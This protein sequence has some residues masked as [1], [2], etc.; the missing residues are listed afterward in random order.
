[1]RV[2]PSFTVLIVDDD[3]AVRDVLVQVIREKGLRVFATS[4][5]YEAIR[6]LGDH[7]VDL[8][9]T[10]IV[11]PGLDGMQLAAQAKLIRPGIKVLFATGYAQKAIERKAFRLG[12]ILFKPVRRADLIREVESLLA[13]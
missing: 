10:D 12:T 6:I 9:L 4:H 3:S 7:P 11:V 2:A 5:G 1:M 8:L 13:A